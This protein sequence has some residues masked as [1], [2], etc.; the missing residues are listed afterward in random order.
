MKPIPY[1]QKGT[2]GGV[3]FPAVEY[4][5]T[6]VP[7]TQDGWY[8]AADGGEIEIVLFERGICWAAGQDEQY[9][10]EK[11]YTHWLGPLPVPDVPK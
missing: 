2:L 10:P 7:P 8:W 3:I 5:W 4:E 9:V 1:R 11:Y 6:T